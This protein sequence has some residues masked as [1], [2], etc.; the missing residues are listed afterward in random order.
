MLTRILF[1]F[2][3]TSRHQFLMGKWWFRALIAIFLI[4][5]LLGAVIYLQAQISWVSGY[6]NSRVLEST[7]Q[8][9]NN[10]SCSNF[11]WST[12]LMSFAIPV[13]VFYLFQVF[14]FKIII[15]FV[16]LGNKSNKLK[17]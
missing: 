3:N 15:D 1:P 4:M 17:Y 10:Y 6:C 8:G 11:Y 14:L 2:Y 13:I 9:I 7:W 5:F 16:A 12:I